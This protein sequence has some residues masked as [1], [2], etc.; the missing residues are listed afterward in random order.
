M[1][2]KMEQQ[3][4]NS[5]TKSVLGFGLVTILLSGCSSLPNVLNVTTKPI[6][7]PILVLPSVDQVQMRRVHW[8][9]INKDNVDEELAKLE[10]QSIPTG[11][12]SL[13][14]EGYEN[15]GLNFSDIRALV[16][17]QQAI[18]VAYQNYYVAAEE[19]LDTVAAK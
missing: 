4:A 16:Q 9:V 15:L 1:K 12:Y 14:G 11:L 5:L 8:I 7:K 13:T 17:Q 18:I 6:D 2:K 10:E 3:M 19:T